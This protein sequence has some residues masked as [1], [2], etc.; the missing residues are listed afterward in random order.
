MSRESTR[1]GLRICDL[2][3]DETPPASHHSPMWRAM[4]WTPLMGLLLGP[5]IADA[6]IY[7]WQDLQGVSHYVSDPEDV[8]AEYRA[9]SVMVVKDLQL[10]PLLAASPEPSPTRGEEAVVPAP[11]RVSVPVET[12]YEWGYRAGLDA[13][14]GASQGAPV[15]SIVQNFQF[16]ES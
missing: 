2:A 15:T 13:V 10:S 4:L 6:A 11:E 5:V 9:Q 14:V 16:V 12:S 1:G 3:F 7:G 8:P